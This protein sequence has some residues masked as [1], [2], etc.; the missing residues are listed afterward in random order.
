MVL[1]K[2][3]DKNKKEIKKTIIYDKNDMPK[4]F[5]IIN[6]KLDYSKVELVGGCGIEIYDNVDKRYKKYVL[7]ICSCF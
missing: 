6:N 4:T 2:R 7:I 1:I 5:E 3:M